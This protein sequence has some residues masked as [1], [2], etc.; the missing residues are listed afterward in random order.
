M[1][2]EYGR[3]DREDKCGRFVSP[4][5]SLA[6]DALDTWADEVEGL[7]AKAKKNGQRVPFDP[8]SLMK[9]LKHSSKF[10]ERLHNLVGYPIRDIKAVSDMYLIGGLPYDG[11]TCFPFIDTSGEIRAVQVKRFDRWNHTA[12]GTNFLHSI[13]KRDCEKFGKPVPGWIEAYDNQAHK[14]TCLF[15]D[16]LLSRYP[17]ATIA[18]VE[19]PKTAIYGTLSFGLPETSGVLWLAVYNKSSLSLEKFRSLK[20]RRVVLFP[21]LSKDGG[22]FEQWKAKAESFARLLPGTIVETSDI[23]ERYANDQEKNRGLDLA[24]FLEGQDWRKLRRRFAP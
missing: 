11:A 16:H 12:G 4:Y 7:P 17:R 23:L 9:T 19:A 18:L 13:I 20:G 8:Q 5:K 15:G 21:D 3:C 24:D 22:T 2:P 14:I 1:P 6:P 10:M